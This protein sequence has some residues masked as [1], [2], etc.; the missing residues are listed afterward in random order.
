MYSKLLS[1]AAL[2]FSV[3]GLMQ[4]DV[5]TTFF[6]SQFNGDEFPIALDTCIPLDITGGN[7]Y[8]KASCNSDGDAVTWI[9]YPTSA[10]AIEALTM[11]FN[12]TYKTGLGT[13]GD[14][15][16]D[17]SGSYYASVDF[18]TTACGETGITYVT[19]NTAV[20]VCTLTGP[21]AGEPVSD[22]VGIEVY[23]QENWVELQYFDVANPTFYQ[24]SCTEEYLTSIANTTEECGFMLQ[25]G[26]TKVYG[27]VM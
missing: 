1:A 20:G 2:L 5:D 10:C 23:C 11:E 17:A 21:Y 22:W 9:Y 4:N 24:V 26:G 6:I 14:F 12:E 16:C 13:Y 3:N 19:M 25:T 27:L 7:G 15:N 8:Q 18:T